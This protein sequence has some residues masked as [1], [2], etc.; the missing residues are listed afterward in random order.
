MTS[1]EITLQGDYCD[2]FRMLSDRFAQFASRFA[3]IYRHG[4]GLRQ[5]M[6]TEKAIPDRIAVVYNGSDTKRGFPLK[7]TRSLVWQRAD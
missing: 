7:F 5:G 2:G 6:E 1:Y 3:H 4:N